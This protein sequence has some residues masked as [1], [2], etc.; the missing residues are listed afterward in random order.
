VLAAL[1]KALLPRKDEPEGLVSAALDALGPYAHFV[2][3]ALVCHAVLRARG[4]AAPLRATVALSLYAAGGPA[5]A[6]SLPFVVL[7]SW[8]TAT[9][10]A[11]NVDLRKG[12]ALFWLVIALGLL[13]LVSFAATLALALARLH[14]VRARWP[15]LGLALALLAS[16]FF[17]GHLD[18]PG[19]YGIHANLALRVQKTGPHSRKVQ[20]NFGLGF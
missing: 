10:Q 18:P 19:T 15:A 6:L 9:G 17:F 3:L 4:G 1:L 12:S 11:S 7:A 13:A 5:A 20:W 16:A 2:A 8:L 14:R